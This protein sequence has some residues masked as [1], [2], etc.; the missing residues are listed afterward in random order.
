MAGKRTNITKILTA[1]ADYRLMS[2]TQLSIYF[3]ITKQAVWKNIRKLISSG[4]IKELQ[5][6]IGR[7]RG[8]PESMY[9]L[10]ELGANDLRNKGILGHDNDED[11]KFLMADNLPH[12]EHQILQN[13]F[14]LHLVYANRQNKV[15][16]EDIPTNSSLYWRG[17]NHRKLHYHYP[18][19]TTLSSKQID[20]LPDVVFRTLEKTT[21]K[22]LL[23]F[24]EIDRGTENLMSPDRKSQGYISDKITN[25]MYYKAYRVYKHYEQVWDCKFEGFRLLF[26][27]N[28]SKRCARL[29]EVIG[30]FEQYNRFIWATDL[31]KLFDSGI[32]GYIWYPGGQMIVPADSILGRLAFDCPFPKIKYYS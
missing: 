29:C 25:Y 27:A 31:E 12:I 23:F 4:S 16:F 11:N 20:F 22:S 19:F 21:G 26:V 9:S 7:S 14:R 17:N 1:I 13:W 15:K 18:P 24:V 3:G 8:R 30:S 5:K 28:N 2:A 10:T 32:G 6:E